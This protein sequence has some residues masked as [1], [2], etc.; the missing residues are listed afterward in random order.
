ML[1]DCLL[2]LRVGYLKK[3]LYWTFRW[4][5]KIIRHLKANKQ[6][7]CWLWH[8]VNIII[9]SKRKTQRSQR[10][11][12]YLNH[13]WLKKWDLKGKECN[14]LHFTLTSCIVSNTFIKRVL[15]TLKGGLCFVKNI[16]FFLCNSWVNLMIDILR[17]RISTLD[18]VFMYKN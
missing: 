3:S 1:F 16:F 4:R 6:S 2:F 9:Y 5:Q 8:S 14:C 10:I 12:N 15:T 18:R 17:R 13:W 7:N 11:C